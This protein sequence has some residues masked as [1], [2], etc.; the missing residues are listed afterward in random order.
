VI[1][2]R[3][4]YAVDTRTDRIGH[5]MGHHGEF[6]RLRPPGGGREWDCPPEALRPAAPRDELRAKVT[7]INREG[8]LP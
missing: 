4:S 7:E 2:K 3:G 1:P 8:R 6:V 5:V